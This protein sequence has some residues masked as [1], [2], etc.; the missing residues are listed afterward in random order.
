MKSLKLD[1]VGT[2][3]LGG[4]DELLGQLGVTVVVHAGFGDDKSSATV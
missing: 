2:A 1:A 4:L 3:G